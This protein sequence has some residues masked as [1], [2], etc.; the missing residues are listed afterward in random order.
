MNPRFNERHSR[1]EGAILVIA[2]LITT[3]VA[4]VTGALLAFAGNGFLATVQLR[5][6]ANTAY[7]ADAATQLAINNLE[8]GAKNTADPGAVYPADHDFPPDNFGLPNTHV[9]WVY[10]NNVDGTGCFGINGNGTPRTSITL[11]NVNTSTGP[12]TA[13]VTCS[14]VLGTGIFGTAP[15]TKNDGTGRAVTILGS[16]GITISAQGNQATFQM[17]GDLASAGPLTINQGVLQ[18]TGKVTAN[19]CPATSAVRADGPCVPSGGSVGDPFKNRS[20]DLP[21][22]PTALGTWSACVFQPGYYDDAKAL[23]DATDLC[24]KSV[25]LP[26]PYYFDFHNNSADPTYSPF[27]MSG[28]TSD[29]WTINN[30]VVGGDTS[31]GTGQVPGR[32]KNPVDSRAS[33]GNAG[34]QFVFGGDSRVLLGSGASVEVCAPRLPQQEQEPIAIFGLDGSS[35]SRGALSSGYEAALQR[36]PSVT[37]TTVAS[38]KTNTQP[39]F[40]PSPASLTDKDALATE[41]GKSEV[42]SQSSGNTAAAMTLNGFSPASTIPVG[43][44]LTAAKL[45]VTHSESTSGTQGKPSIT[46][47]LSV[48]IGAV[49][50]ASIAG[51]TNTSTAANPGSLKRDTIDLSSNSTVMKA[52]ARAVHSGDI[53]S[54]STTFTESASGKTSASLDFVQLQLTYYAPTLRGESSA[55]ISGNCIAAHS[56]DVIS[57]GATGTGG[58]KTANS[59]FAGSFVV[60]GVAYVPNGG[61]CAALG[62][63]TAVVSFRWGIVADHAYLGSL[64]QFPYSYPV[65]SIPS[66]GP[67]FGAAVTAVDLRVFLCSGSGPCGGAPVLTSRV[68][69]TDPVDPLTSL[70]NPSP[71]NRKIDVMSFSEQR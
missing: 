9:P 19:P 37:A 24:P 38:S 58:C 23:T 26:G 11:P 30:T 49:N 22:V 45:V 8:L 68:R 36:S 48:T 31:N 32:C 27:A 33:T 61:V 46:P 65:V 51:L 4:L 12:S 57:T 64:N 55:A 43:S 3:A 17:R 13:T 60:Q 5:Q 54:F 7:V 16:G 59:S 67:G 50:N 47:G 40:K 63:Q 39:D 18:T 25:F 41:D 62:N 66:Q 42:F 70:V 69:I 29:V 56:C 1:D 52:L 21:S 20:P 15:G 53:S 14:P 44:L 34:V 6:V 28:G 35:M 2:L 71:G 10:D